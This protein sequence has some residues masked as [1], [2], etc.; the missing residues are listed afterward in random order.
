MRYTTLDDCHTATGI[1]LIIDVLRA[2]STAAY[3]FSRGA[4]EIRLV[5]TVEEA[6]MLRKEIPNS[7]AFG[8][9]GGIPPEG[10]DFGNS[11][12][13]ILEQELNGL[14]LIQRTGAGTQGA[15]RSVHAEVM[16]A[17][18]FVVAQ[19]TVQAVSNLKPDELTFVITG[20]VD[21]AEDMACAELL[22]GLFK[23]RPVETQDYIHRVYAARDAVLHLAGH[24]QFPKSDLDYCTRVNA[25]NFT[26]P[27][28]R[29]TAQLVMRAVKN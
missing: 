14:S 5:G 26:M 18:S 19:A 7:R 20:G 21:N 1:V 8:E 25:F 13:L 28:V 12:T 4:A 11:P 6:L 2:F 24:P 27:I 9:V 22:E 29:E 15:V 16:F 10:F 17:T 3:A 23:G